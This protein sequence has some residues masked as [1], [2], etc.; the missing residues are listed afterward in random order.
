M[1][2]EEKSTKEST[3][4]N[5]V[6]AQINLGV[7]TPTHLRFARLMT[8]AGSTSAREF[9]NALMDA[10]EN[11][12]V[13]TDN[14]SVIE[15]LQN[16]IG[17]LS[18]QVQERDAKIKELDANLEEARRIANENAENGLGKQLQIDELQQRIDG[19][20][21]LRPNPVVRY[22][23]DEMAKKTETA[24]DKILEKLFIDDLQN[25]MAN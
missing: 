1:E 9:C 7:G 19:A 20:I 16:E 22:F 17:K 25:P 3:K 24:P 14:S 4:V 11:P 5:G 10:Y 23:L 12:V 8:D 18:S 15:N 13:G 6:S 21:I 2:N